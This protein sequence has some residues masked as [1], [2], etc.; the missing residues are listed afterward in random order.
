MQGKRSRSAGQLWTTTLLPAAL[1]FW[2]LPGAIAAMPFPVATHAPNLSVHESCYGTSLRDGHREN[3]QGLEI[4]I[5]SHRAPGSSYRV[6]CFFLKRGKNGEAPS[7]DD[8]TVFEVTDPHGVYRVMAKPIRMG[9]SPSKASAKKS[10]SKKPS[11]P[12]VPAPREGYL[13]R[14][15]SEGVL[16]RECSSSHSVERLAA[17][18]PGLFT[19]AL[20]GKKVRTLE[21]PDL[22]VR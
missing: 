20:A 17:E 22:L 7:V 8:V 14:V 15:L 1:I 4:R 18:D 19:G 21:A 2:T 3:I 6:E 13:V 11:T 10:V 12:V 5:V 16:L 9:A